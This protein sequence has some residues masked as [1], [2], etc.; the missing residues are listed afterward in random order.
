MSCVT[1]ILY[2]T[3]YVVNRKKKK[4]AHFFFFFLKCLR[5]SCNIIFKRISSFQ[6]KLTCLIWFNPTTPP[7]P[8]PIKFAGTIWNVPLR[9]PW[10]LSTLILKKD[11]IYRTK[12]LKVSLIM[13]INEKTNAMLAKYGLW[14]YYCSKFELIMR[15][16][17][18][19]FGSIFTITFPVI[20]QR[21]V[22]NI[23]LTSFL[24]LRHTLSSLMPLRILCL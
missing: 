2:N 17:E 23:V 24:I 5:R 22:K 6:V 15:K 1:L 4:Q 9:R 19:I 20:F 7:S 12:N 13:Q 8:T 10:W 18:L 11:F 3:F 14:T 21:S 16:F